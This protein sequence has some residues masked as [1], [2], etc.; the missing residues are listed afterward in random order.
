MRR[1]ALP[2]FGS[3][4]GLFA[5]GVAAVDCGND[6]QGVDACRTIESR[7]CELVRGCPAS[8]VV[9]E[10]DVNVCKLFYR[11]QCMFGIANNAT[12]RAP[13]EALVAACLAALN[14]AAACR[15]DTAS[16]C[17]EPP[18]LATSVE[19][20]PTG[21]ALIGTPE[22]LEACAFLAPRP[23]EGSGGGAG[24]SGGAGGAGGAGGTGAAGGAAT[25]GA[26]GA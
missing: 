4:L 7:R 17:A 11:D 21:C 3:I 10:S 16:T 8:S 13:D 12:V 15:G 18:T 6:A 1:S 20:D 25:G 22:H 5:L 26:G 19:G 14:Q 23:A 2:V 9:S 24:G